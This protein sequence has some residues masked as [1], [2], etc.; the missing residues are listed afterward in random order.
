MTTVADEIT[1]LIANFSLCIR[2]Q[3]VQLQLYDAKGRYTAFVC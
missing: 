2:K 1:N 3:V